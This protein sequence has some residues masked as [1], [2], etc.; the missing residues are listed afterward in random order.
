MTILETGVF[1]FPRIYCCC[2]L[3]CS[4]VNFLSFIFLIIFWIFF[5]EVYILCEVL[6]LKSLCSVSLVVTS[7]STNFLKNLEPNPPP[8]PPNLLAFADVLCVSWS[9]A[10]FDSALGFNS[11]SCGARSA[12]GEHS[13]PSQVFSK[14]ALNPG[15]V[16][17]GL[18]DRQDLWDLSKTIKYLIASLSSLNFSTYLLLA[19]TIIPSSRHQWLIYL[20]SNVH[21][22]CHLHLRRVP[23]SVK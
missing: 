23:N 14:H 19:P 13:E 16:C 3:Y 7:D 5:F 8:P 18:L 22:G 6:P 17:G 4:L 21:Q 10:V 2:L 1:S 15:H 12:R 11:Q 9:Q 20:P